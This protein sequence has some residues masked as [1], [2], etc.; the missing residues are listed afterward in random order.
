MTRI[1]HLQ[2]VQNLRELGGLP[3]AGGRRVAFGR[4]FR[5]GSLHQASPADREALE[6]MGI[7]V[8]I[9]LRSA[10]EQAR[11]SYEWPSGRKV[12]APLAHDEAVAAIFG[13][14]QAET[15][16]PHDM[17]DWWNLTGVFRL[18]QDHAGSM[19]VI[20]RTLAEVEEGQAVLFHCTGG[21]DRTGVVAAFI[22]EAL[23]A[24]RPAIVEDFLLTNEGAQ[25]RAAEFVEWIRRATGRAMSLETAYWL[26]GVKSEWLEL[27]LAQTDQRYGSVAGYLREELGFGPDEVANLRARY[28]EPAGA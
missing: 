25:A 13:R 11:Q 4:L 3:A 18:P 22:L 27:L 28:L 12:A 21:K 20:F 9:D 7:R 23:G 15:L 5:S 19:R 26:A 1:I 14:F 10:F 24:P 17:E 2:T 8:V 6:A 16:S